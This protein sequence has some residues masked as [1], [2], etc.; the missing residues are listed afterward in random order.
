MLQ[1][2]SRCF[3]LHW[4]GLLPLKVSYWVNAVLVGKLG[5]FFLDELLGPRSPVHDGSAGVHIAARSAWMCANAGLFVW[6]VVGAWR[7]AT[8]YSQEDPHS[9]GAVAK[10]A[11][12]I[13]SVLWALKIATVLS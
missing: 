4:R 7:S 9:W 5:A 8:I 6:C 12:F 2:V 13:A 11:L 1:T 3:R 10:G